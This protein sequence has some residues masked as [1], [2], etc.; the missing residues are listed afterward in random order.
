VPGVTEVLTA[1]RADLVAAGLVRRASDPRA[2]GATPPP[3]MVNEPPE[4]PP[5]PGDDLGD[6]LTGD[7][8]LVLSLIGSGEVSPANSYDAAVARTITLDVRY[9]SRTAAALRRAEALDAA[10][11][12]RLIRPETNYGYGFTLAE[13]TPAAI[14]VQAVGIF[15]GFSPVNRSRAGGYDHRASYAVTVTPG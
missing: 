1:F 5:G 10:I 3:P 11:R 15:A 14:L 6:G 9:R 12:A 2:A 7:P 8:E 13:G 4:G